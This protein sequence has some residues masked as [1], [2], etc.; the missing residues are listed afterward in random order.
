VTR[1]A[2]R[3]IVTLVLVAVTSVPAGVFCAHECGD[4]ALAEAAS[5]DQHCHEPAD[6]GVR[7]SAAAADGCAVL[8]FTEPATRERVTRTQGDLPV[9]EAP[10]LVGTPT[11][12]LAISRIFVP[13]FPPGRG[14]SPGTIV[15]LRI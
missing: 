2:A 9:I 3:F 14:I 4:A 15:P 10:P 8:S 1:S 5:S 13:D 7:L 12:S 11:A 6:D